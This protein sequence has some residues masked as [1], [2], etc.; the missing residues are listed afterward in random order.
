MDPITFEKI[1]IKYIFHDK[2]ARE[3]IIPVLSSKIFD[4]FENK[5]LAK[6]IKKFI[7][8]YKHWLKKEN[9]DNIISII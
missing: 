6:F 2:E 9:Y 5:E 8:E 7:D 3:I 1:L 4:N